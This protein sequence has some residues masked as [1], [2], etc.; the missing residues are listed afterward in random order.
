M[1]GVIY[2]TETPG[3]LEQHGLALE[4]NIQNMHMHVMHTYGINTDGY[5]HV[6]GAFLSDIAGSFQSR[7]E[8]RH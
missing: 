1:I 6:Y 5:I 2:G 7:G 4:D 8:I 3:L